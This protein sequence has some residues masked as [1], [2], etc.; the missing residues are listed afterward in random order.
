MAATSKQKSNSSD[1]SASK[2]QNS[3][4]N[5]ESA[6]DST[7]THI[8]DLQWH[9]ISE[10]DLERLLENGFCTVQS[11]SH[12]TVR[13]LMEIRGISEEKALKLKAIVNDICPIGF[14]SAK[15]VGKEREKVVMISTGSKDLDAI[16]NGGIETGSLTEVF[17]EF[18]TGKTQLCHTMCVTCQLPMSEGGFAG[19]AMYIDTEGTF[20]P[21]K[22]K[23]I[24]ERF[25][26][27]AD[28]VLENVAIARVHNR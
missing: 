4:S 17:G 8:N 27:D 13:K 1:D 19:K 7:F 18:R 9:G 28:A 21:Q 6:K 12:A 2:Y 22:I 25:N 20:R 26:L 10:S 11:I 23:A 14:K 15:A 24:A 5:H 3:E 16:L